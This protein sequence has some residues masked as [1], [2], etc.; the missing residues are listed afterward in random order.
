MF[1]NKMWLVSHAFSKS[2]NDYPDKVLFY[3]DMTQVMDDFSDGT[4]TRR[5]FSV[6]GSVSRRI[7]EICGSIGEN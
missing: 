5:V 4:K 6:C 7:E 1:Q 3:H 2:Q